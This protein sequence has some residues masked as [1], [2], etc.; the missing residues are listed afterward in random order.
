M[1]STVVATRGLPLRVML[2]GSRKA[3]YRLG[4]V[5]GP[6]R[7]TSE[8]MLVFLR[9]PPVQQVG[10]GSHSG[11]AAETTVLNGNSA[12]IWTFTSTGTH[13]VSFRVDVDNSVAALKR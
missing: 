11:V 10:Y 3:F 5:W 4:R 12:L 7:I 1:T 13:R 2:P 6:N 8:K 9:S